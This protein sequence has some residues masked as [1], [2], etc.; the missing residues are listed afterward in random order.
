MSVP[1]SKRK[2]NKLEVFNLARDL[3]TYTIR[4]TANEKVFLPQYKGA[5]TDDI[6]E[7]AKNIYADAWE[8][9]NIYVNMAP[10]DE[11]ERMKAVR[12]WMD[13][14]ELQQKAV[15]EC[16]R[17]LTLIGTAKSVFHLKGK[18]VKYWVGKVLTVR[19]KIRNWKDSD[20]KRYSEALGKALL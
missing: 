4:I 14:R 15:R 3:T 8:A 17:L 11:I 6:I 18:R 10:K 13:R 2:E 7:T 12:D 1:E 16:N 9:N 20:N 5:V 19:N